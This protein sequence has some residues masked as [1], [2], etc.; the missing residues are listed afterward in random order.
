MAQER[1]ESRDRPTAKDAQAGDGRVAAHA[2][3]SAG[4][5]ATAR[6]HARSRSG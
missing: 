6:R 5:A 1:F 3:R 4:P 2:L